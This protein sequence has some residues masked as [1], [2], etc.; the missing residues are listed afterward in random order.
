MEDDGGDSCDHNFY[1]LLELD[2]LK[3]YIRGI[4]AVRIC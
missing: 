2:Y 3:Y 1:R 4:S